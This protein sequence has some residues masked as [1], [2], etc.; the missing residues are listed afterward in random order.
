MR[1]VVHGLLHQTGYDDAT[2][3]GAA[4]MHARE[5]ELLAAFAASRRTARP[6]PR[7]ENK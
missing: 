1:Y 2:V 3:R 4:R 5:D 7:K 6:R